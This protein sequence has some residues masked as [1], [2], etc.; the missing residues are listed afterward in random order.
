MRN[1]RGAALLLAVVALAAVGAMVAGAFLAGWLELRG[2]ASARHAIAAFEA[3]E[4]G[5]VE[6]MAGWSRALG[7]LPAGTDSVVRRDSSGAVGH[8][9]TVTRLRG[10]AFFLRSQGWAAGGAG[11]PLARRMVGIFLRLT[12]LAVEHGSALALG[13]PA[14]LADSA[15][16]SGEDA[17]PAGWSAACGAAAGS[18][19]A[20]RT[21]GA[22]IV[23]DSGPAPA[24]VLDTLLGPASF[25][26]FGV[27]SFAELAAAADLRVSGTVVPAP[28]AAGGRC[29][30]D[31]PGNW[32]EPL[33]GAGSVA[34]CFDDL[35]V[36]YAPGSL[37][38]A[39]G[40]GQGILLVGGDL[41]LGG[42]ADFRGVVVVLGRVTSGPGGGRI[43]GTL[44]VAGETGETLLGPDIRVAYS[45]CAVSRAAVAAGTPERLR[46]G[47]WA[48]LY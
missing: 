3:A 11:E 22:A 15:V 48:E 40:R 8:V 1:E 9:V 29:S 42:G 38:V 13:G 27:R 35:P 46:E 19:P 5:A 16:V 17:V 21:S 41:E 12:P 14:R 4:A 24:V 44:L 28:A 45:S 36:V 23:V 34:P 2:A 25:R 6:A 26:S 43:A 20:V 37:V 47:A 39:G 7:R 33:T 18:V 10:S 31:D 30:A 32:G